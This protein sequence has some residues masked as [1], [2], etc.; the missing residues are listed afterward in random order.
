MKR[1][2]ASHV[3]DIIFTLG[4]FCVL[5]ASLLTVVLLGANVYGKTVET[6]RQNYEKRTA[7]GYV[8]GK[9]RQCENAGAVSLGE[10]GDLP[11]L[12]LREQVGGQ[13]L[14][15]YIYYYDGALCEV[16]A[17]EQARLGPQN[18]QR[19]LEV[20]H[21]SVHEAEPGLFWLSCTDAAGV[22]T[23]ALAGVRGR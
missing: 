7:I 19:I 11:A 17:N 22:K 2:N 13:T 23:R 5:A 1:N 4:L 12:V 20:A 18:G 9:L 16:F 15:T 8:T 6:M 21:F 3:V 14:L 10:L